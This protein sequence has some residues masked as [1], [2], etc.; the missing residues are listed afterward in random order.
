MSTWVGP[1]VITS[2]PSQV[3]VNVKPANTVGKTITKHVTCLRRFTGTEGYVR[4]QVQ[5]EIEDDGDDLAEE[6]GETDR[7]L[8]PELD[9][10]VPVHTVTAAPKMADIERPAPAPPSPQQQMTPEK[11]QVVPEVTAAPPAKSNAE[12]RDERANRRAERAEQA[13]RRAA[14]LSHM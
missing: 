5:V 11:Q 9:L 1:Y 4:G 3:L 10:G 2:V 6:I 14:Q 13:A 8:V 12:R 7:D